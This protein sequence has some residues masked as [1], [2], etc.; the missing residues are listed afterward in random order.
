MGIPAAAR[1]LAGGFSGDG[2]IAP[3]GSRRYL[4]KF[5]RGLRRR[6]K[7]GR[8]SSR[9]AGKEERV[10]ATRRR[11]SETTFARLSAV[12]A[13]ICAVRE[14]EQRLRAAYSEQRPAGFQRRLPLQ[15][16]S[17]HRQCSVLLLHPQGGTIV[18]PAFE[19]IGDGLESE[20]GSCGAGHAVD[21]LFAG[22]AGIPGAAA[23]AAGCSKTSGG[24]SSVLFYRLGAGLHSGRSHVHSAVRLVP[25]ASDLCAYG[26]SFSDA[27]FERGGQPVLQQLVSRQPEDMVTA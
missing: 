15:R 18:K 5:H 8:D 13:L 2:S 25:G 24:F 4:A 22:G 7:R 14:R 16:N 20:S 1:S 17:S 10:H 27:A 9:R 23:D 12:E 26:G 21:S 11:D 3:T 19:F 6:F